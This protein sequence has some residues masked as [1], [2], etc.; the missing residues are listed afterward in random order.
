MMG[1]GS[2][3]RDGGGRSGGMA[4]QNPQVTPDTAT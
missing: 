3:S 2:R 4:A 1:V